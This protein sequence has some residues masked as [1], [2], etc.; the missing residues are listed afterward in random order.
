MHRIAL[1]CCST[2]R[3]LIFLLVF[4]LPGVARAQGSALPGNPVTL[5]NAPQRDTTQRGPSES[6]DTDNTVRISSRTA[7]DPAPEAPD[8]SIRS[9]HRRLVALPYS[10]DLGNLG[11]P[12]RP[13][14]F[15]PGTPLTGPS[16]GIRVFDA[17][18]FGPGNLRYYNSTRPYSVFSFSLG[19][20]Q[21]S[22]VEL[23][24]TQNIRPYWNAA[25]TYRKITSPGFYKGQRT[26][27]DNGALST[28]YSSPSA[29]YELFGGIV[30][31]KEQND[32][33]GGI[34]SADFLTDDDYTDRRTIPVRFNPDAYSTRRSPV[35]NALRDAGVHIQHSYTIGPADTLYNTDTT[36]YSVTVK[37]R[38]RVEHTVDAGSQ[39][40]AYNDL[41]PDSLRYTGLYEQRFSS[42][43]SVYSRQRWAWWDNAVQVS[44]FAGKRGFA[45]TAGAGL[46]RDAFKT[47]VIGS[48]DEERAITGL[49]L[50]GSIGNA[51]ATIRDTAIQSR[52][53][54]FG[55]SGKL[56]ISGSAAG[57]YVV[58]GYARKQLGGTLVRAHFM[59][60]L[61]EPP[62]AYTLY[63]NQ[64]FRKEESLKQ[65]S[66]TTAMLE[67]AVPRIGA[68]ASARLWLLANYIYLSG[69]QTFAQHAP[70][71]NIAQASLQKRF[72][73]GKW[74]F[75]GEGILQTFSGAGPVN[76]P[77]FAAR[78][79]GAYES[80]VFRRAL[81]VAAGAELRYHT[82]YYADGYTPMF[83]RFYFQDTT[84]ISNPPELTAF[85]NFRIKRFRGTLAGDQLQQLLFRRNV[86]RSPGYPA[87][88]ALFRFGFSWVLVN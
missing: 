27:H 57:N 40:W 80:A 14:L 19:S 11:S 76:L 86:L 84:R 78:A 8:T 87:P 33:N 13:I 43:D 34:R 17:Y 59:Q 9:L 4:A 47:T 23:L 42:G 48:N 12:V 70:A 71:F 75:S 7:D 50:T 74:T 82:P 52:G 24:H 51:T 44:G 55:A 30:Y 72:A 21:E 35:S 5:D 39:F 18:R 37:P 15:Q 79:Q 54:M 65:E 29:R 67:A 20:R 88:N 41:R 28:H 31:N 49:Y 69:D 63:R 68:T 77:L 36:E 61:R 6:W 16:L 2:V 32:E 60:S 73:A 26:N 45:V 81:T 3:R 38:L 46:R 10:A 64:Y 58:D 66:I 1:R 56:F 53:L 22:A 83:A 25:F 62:Y 85:F